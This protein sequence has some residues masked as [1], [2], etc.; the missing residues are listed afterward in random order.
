MH[1]EIVKH[2]WVKSDCPEGSRVEGTA[3]RMTFF[4]QDAVDE[5]AGIRASREAE[6][7]DFGVRWREMWPSDLHTGVNEFLNR[8]DRIV[9]KKSEYETQRSGDGVGGEVPP[10]RQRLYFCARQVCITKSSPY[11]QGFLSGKDKF[12]TMYGRSGEERHGIP[13][14]ELFLKL[15]SGAVGGE[16]SG[17]SNG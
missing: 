4:N 3:K 5:H 13:F 7:L 14:V 11:V 1:A 8:S 10:R 2:D 15:C 16:A 6:D 12:Q 17:V 9:S